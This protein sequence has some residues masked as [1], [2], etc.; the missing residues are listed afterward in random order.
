M[1]ELYLADERALSPFLA[2]LSCRGG[3]EACKGKNYAQH[4]SQKGGEENAQIGWKHKGYGLGR[5]PEQG[6]G[7]L[8]NESPHDFPVYII[9]PLSCL[10]W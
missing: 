8:K 10:H 7:L 3:G 2:G 6:N 9:E 5:Y 4:T 1:Y